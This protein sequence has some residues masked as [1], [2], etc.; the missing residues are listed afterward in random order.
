MSLLTVEN[1][2]KSFGTLE[3]LK[4]VS[5]SVNAGEV[6]SVI[7]PS[8]SGK[9]T[10]LRCITLLERVDSG[11]IVIDG[12]TMVGTQGGVTTYANEKQLHSLRMRIGLVFQNFNLFPHLSVLENITEAQ[13]IV[14][15]IGREAANAT[16]MSL[17]DKMGLADKRDAY[18]CELS[19]G[20]SQRVAI[21]RALALKPVVLC[22]DEPTSALDPELTGEVLRAIRALKDEHLTMVVVTHEMSFAKE[23]SDHVAFMD[24]GIL[25]AY[26]TPREI[27][28]DTAH[29]RL[30][31]F[32]NNVD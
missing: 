26:G 7:G 32:L 10:L 29:P 11:S 25:A 31:A 4:G 30:R 13:R 22:F 17:L 8:G 5:V 3:V 15:K 24:G 12:Q 28:E 21:A 9:S 16:A 27:L 14:A 19:G 1:V 18:P 23:V 6:L 20:Q 2:R